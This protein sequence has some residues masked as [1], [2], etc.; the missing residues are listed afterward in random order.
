MNISTLKYLHMDYT[1]YK[2][3]Q[4]DTNIET[5]SFSIFAHLD[6]MPT[7]VFTFF[8]AQKKIYYCQNVRNAFMFVLL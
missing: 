8:P 2:I 1:R 5:F 7:E 3:E 4:P 6:F